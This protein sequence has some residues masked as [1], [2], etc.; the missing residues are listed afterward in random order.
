MKDIIITGGM[1]VCGEEGIIFCNDFEVDGLQGIARWG[2]LNTIKKSEL[3]F[4]IQ[5]RRFEIYRKDELIVNKHL[6]ELRG[7]IGDIMHYKEG[8]SKFLGESLGIKQRA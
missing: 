6:K 4:K 7:G 8:V 2:A 3:S 1:T 5:G